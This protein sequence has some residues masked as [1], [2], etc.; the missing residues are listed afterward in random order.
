M[1]STKQFY[2][3]YEQKVDAYLTYTNQTIRIT[4]SLQS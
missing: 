2:D 3:K 1:K 4:M